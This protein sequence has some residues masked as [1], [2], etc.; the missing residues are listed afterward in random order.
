MDRGAYLRALT[1]AV[2]KA[3]SSGISSTGSVDSDISPEVSR[4]CV[5]S[6][7]VSVSPRISIGDCVGGDSKPIGAV[8]LDGENGS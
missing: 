1:G 3:F 8:G 4:R 5:V 6:A 7:T 2:S